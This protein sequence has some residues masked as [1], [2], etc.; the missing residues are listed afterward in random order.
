MNLLCLLNRQGLVRPG[1]HCRHFELHIACG[2]HERVH[3]VI[4]SRRSIHCS[5]NRQITA[6]TRYDSHLFATDENI[7]GKQIFRRVGSV[8]LGEDGDILHR[9]GCGG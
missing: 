2:A 8:E 7:E 3:R 6:R 4:V 5:D 9:Y 1:L